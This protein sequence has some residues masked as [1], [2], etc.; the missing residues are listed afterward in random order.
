ME[1]KLFTPEE[2]NALLPQLRAELAKLQELAR[3]I[4]NGQ[5]E[6]HRAKTAQRTLTEGAQTRGAESDP[7]FL[8]ETR[9]DF[10]RMEAQML[11][12]NFSRNGVLLKMIEP[13]L[14]DFPAIVDGEE[15]LICWKEGE[16]R[17]THYHGWHDGFAGRKP[18]P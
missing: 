2:A 18:L 3:D 9:I 13:G 5:K 10:M 4:E 14:L 7:F 17:A 6:L 11:I 8:M 16:E 15:A 1:R 12:D